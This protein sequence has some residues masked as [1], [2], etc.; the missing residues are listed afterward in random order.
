MEKATNL[1]DC[2]KIKTVFRETDTTRS[3]I[4]RMREHQV[5]FFGPVMRREKSE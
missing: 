2:K 1:M 4:N 3:L 5:T